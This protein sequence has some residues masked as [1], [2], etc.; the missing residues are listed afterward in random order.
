MSRLSTLSLRSFAH[1]VVP[2]DGSDPMVDV[3]T[4][5]SP[6]AGDRPSG[7]SLRYEGTYDDIQ[8]ARHEEDPNLPQGVWQT[9]VKVAD[10]KTVK[11][12]CLQALDSKSKDLQIAVW[13]SEA[14]ARLHGFGGV[15]V[16]LELITALC[17][18]QWSTLHP[19]LDDD[20]DPEAR[21]NCFSWLNEGMALCLS[22]LPLALAED[23]PAFS[24]ADIEAAAPEVDDEDD[25]PRD[26]GRRVP[27][28][29]HIL[30]ALTLTPAEHVQACYWG[31]MRAL[32]ALDSLDA[33]L[34]QQLERNQQPGFGR[35]RHV[36]NGAVG[37]LRRELD[38]RGLPTQKPQAIAL[39]E[40]EA[41]PKDQD[42]DQE[43]DQD[44]DDSDGANKAESAPNGGMPSTRGEAAMP[45]ETVLRGPIRS[46]GEAFEA[47]AE[48]ADFLS[49]TEPHSPV[50]YLIR[51]AIRWGGM[52]LAD[53]LAEL[54]EEGHDRM[55]LMEM[56]DMT[57]D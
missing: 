6:L 43:Q 47:L 7:E 2:G 15:A 20:G 39:V 45:E 57:Q 4:L 29:R 30:E 13:L 19:E 38:D 51:R 32:A 17:Q 31:I 23:C 34:A 42:Q 28:L 54:L 37:R 11:T 55:R 36:L 53:L 12:L 52:P 25:L 14:L 8:A 44:Q 22:R 3:A 49:R 18:Q 9:A 56:L 46:R 5:A 21:L 26:G 50:P 27:A 35:L 24:F 1:R 41:A 33:I 10:W 40:A 16:G 48:A